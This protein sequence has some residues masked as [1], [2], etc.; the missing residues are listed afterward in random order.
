MTLLLC[1][2]D[3]NFDSRSA[4]YIENYPVEGEIYTLRGRTHTPNGMGYLLEEIHN[5]PMR[6]RNG[7]EPSFAAHRFRKIDNKTDINQLI[8]ENE[9][10]DFNAY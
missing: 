1:I 2:N 4:E 5:P 3:K 7:E 6:E 10:A 8:E 9:E